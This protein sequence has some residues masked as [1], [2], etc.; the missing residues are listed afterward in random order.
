MLASLYTTVMVAL[1]QRYDAFPRLGV[2]VAIAIAIAYAATIFAIDAFT[3]VDDAISVLYVLDILF[4]ASTAPRR[5]TIVAGCACAVLT[6]IGYLFSHAGRYPDEVL[7]HCV[8]SI[9]ANC[10]TTFLASR[11]QSNTSRLRE[12][13]ELLN[14]THDA[15]IAYDMNG[16]ITFWNDGAERV[17]GWHAKD[18]SHQD[19]DSLLNTRYQTPRD[20][21]QR[22]LLKS[23]QWRG[24]LQRTRKDGSMVVISSRLS[25]WRGPNGTPI[26]VLATSNDLTEIRKAQDA[27]SR[28]KAELAHVSRVSLLGEMAASIAHEVAQ[29]MTGIITCGE[30]AIRW[31]ERPAPDV[32]E[33]VPL[34]RQI[35]EDANRATGI[36]S[37]IR[38]MAQKREQGHSIVDINA[39]VKDSLALVQRDLRTQ[40]IRVDLDLFSPKLTVYGDRVQLQQVLIN[41]ILNSVQAMRDMTLP[42]KT[43][44]I[45]TAVKDKDSLLVTVK[46]VG[47]GISSNDIGRL[48]A[49][50]FTT[51]SDGMGM[52]LSICRSIIESHGGKIWVESPK[53]GGALMQI[54]LPIHAMA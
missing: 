12:Q 22:E 54:A 26:A 20:D 11:N 45:T 53:E 18:A 29:P 39:T 33:A 15:I 30:A 1:R 47:V 41:L 16:R 52:G 9:L 31:L 46:D 34:L 44:H 36:V 2:P 24:E 49:P 13:V 25:L 7:S 48:F 38:S 8:V 35:I 14:L 5:A 27:L 3:Q 17:Y 42:A 32:V 50:F 43:I 19:I 37:Q 23:G 4:V 6:V 10:V 40:E 21:V 51:K 28:S